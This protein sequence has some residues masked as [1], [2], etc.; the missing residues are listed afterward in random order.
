MSFFKTRLV[1]LAVSLALGV[2]GMAH[3]AQGSDHRGGG[4]SSHGAAGSGKGSGGGTKGEGSRGD[5]GAPSARKEHEENRTRPRFHDQV[6]DGSK[7][8]ASG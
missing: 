6:A 1:I 5:E 2:S 7:Q 3:V 8:R 4:V